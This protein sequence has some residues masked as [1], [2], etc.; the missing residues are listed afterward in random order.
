MPPPLLRVRSNW[1]STGCNRQPGGQDIFGG[2]NVAIMQSTTTGTFPVTDTL[3]HRFHHVPALRTS[4]AAR[5][6]AVY[7]HQGAPIP[8][9]FVLQ[10]TDQLAPRRIGNGSAVSLTPQHPFDAQV[11][12]GDQLVFLDQPCRELM[13]VIFARVGDPGVDTGNPLPRLLAITRALLLLGEPL[14]RLCQADAMA[15][16]ATRVLDRLALAGDQQT[17]EPQVHTDAALDR[18]ELPDRM[19]VHQQGHMPTPS[20]RKAD[21]HSGRR[22]AFRNLSAPTNRQRL[23]AFSQ[24]QPPITP[25]ESRASELSRSA[26]AFLLE[27]RVSSP[28]RE[29]VGE[30]RLEVPQCL[31]QRD[32]GDLVEE[33]Q[34]ILLLPAGEHGAGLEIGDRLRLRAPNRA[35]SIQ[36]PVV[37]QTH[38]TQCPTQERFLLGCGIEAV[39]EGS[40]HH[41]ILQDRRGSV[42]VHAGASSPVAP[43]AIPPRPEVRGF[44]RVSK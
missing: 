35:A 27:V 25:T 43:V 32:A 1:C 13:Q 6:E 10:L 2:I 42:R 40:L 7:L 29:E 3:R 23:L 19:V 16:E 31:L 41:Y 18:W 5:E 44:S 24:K 11:L 38:A 21:R 30:R 33:L 8:I 12:D 9:G 36:R 28:L 39:A 4:L 15:V 34:I 22:A 26:I 17:L 14:L 37:D 20:R